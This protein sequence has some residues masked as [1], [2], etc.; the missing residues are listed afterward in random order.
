MIIITSVFGTKRAMSSFILKLNKFFTV[1]AIAAATF[2]TTPAH[3]Y[4]FGYSWFDSGNT[5]NLNGGSTVLENI[6]SGWYN[7]VGHDPNNTNYIAVTTT[8]EA[9]FDRPYNNF[10]VFDISN[11]SGSFTSASF[12]LYSHDVTETAT[13]S[14]FDY[15]GNIDS[16]VAGTDVGALI[17]LSSG[18]LFGSHL[19]DSSQSY[20][21][22]TI[23][24]NS[25]FLNDLNAAIQNG[26]RLFAFGGTLQQPAQA[27]E[28][29]SIALLGI[30]V[31]GLAWSR[32][33]KIA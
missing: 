29:M 14:M 12:T 26:D 32:R 17:D 4:V 15:T 18:A 27:P 1:L 8:D 19:Y 13:Y 16:L 20:T 3:A 6:D 7:T 9:F 28:P 30:G 24:L 33:R 25:A 5:L 22:Q 11:L 21:Y 31:G 23:A 2:V 10:F